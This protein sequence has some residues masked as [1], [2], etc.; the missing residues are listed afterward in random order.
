MGPNTTLL[1]DPNMARKKGTVLEPLLAKAIGLGA[2]QLEVDYKDGS[3]VVFAMKSGV[4]VGIASFRSS[5][6]EAKSLRNELYAL[7]KKRQ[8][9]KIDEHTYELRARIFDSF[10]EDAFRVEL[11]RYKHLGKMAAEK[12]ERQ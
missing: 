6:P 5:S 4:G 1:L 2:D 8:R 7:A 9:T 12:Q 3:E 10:G 11:R